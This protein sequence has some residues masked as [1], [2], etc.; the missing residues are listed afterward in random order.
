LIRSKKGLFNSLLI[1]AKRWYY[2]KVAKASIFKVERYIVIA[3]AAT[4]DV[5]GVYVLEE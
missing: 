4:E 5:F 1:Y 2:P 3:L